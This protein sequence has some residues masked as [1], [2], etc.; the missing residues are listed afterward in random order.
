MKGEE[1]INA[2]PKK[3]SLKK[4]TAKV[5]GEVNNKVSEYSKNIKIIT[6]DYFQTTKHLE[7][8]TDGKLG[9]LKTKDTTSVYN[10]CCEIIPCIH[11]R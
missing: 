9:V 10:H 1:T 8:S 11:C 6:N 4:A 7:I 5:T 3:S 2:N